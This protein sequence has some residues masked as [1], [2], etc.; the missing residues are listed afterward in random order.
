L[1]QNRSVLPAWP[2]L[3]KNSSFIDER[4][5]LLPGSKE[6]KLDIHRTVQC[7]QDGD[8]DY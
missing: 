1:L 6:G 3:A 2:F 4:S 5:Y 8:I 7:F